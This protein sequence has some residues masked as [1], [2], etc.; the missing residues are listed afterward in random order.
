MSLA[1]YRNRIADEKRQQIL[2]AARS[3]FLEQGYTRTSLDGVAKEANVSSATV[4]KHFST[5][6]AL[7][8]AAVESI[9]SENWQL[10]PSSLLPQNPRLTL[11]VA[12]RQYALILRKPYLEPFLR[13]LIAESGRVPE[14]GTQFFQ[15][16]REPIVLALGDFIRKATN[17]GTLFVTEEQIHVVVRQFLS[18]IDGVLI[19]PRLLRPHL[20]I[21]DDEAKRAVDEAVELILA[22]YGSK[23]SS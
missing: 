1:E 15:Q 7:F 17:A 14:M 4:Y 5:K 12:G 3:L 8:G 9:L 20:Q 16:G 21:D 22:R 13:M 6:D 19:W 18:L 11:K 23:S 2:H 10:A